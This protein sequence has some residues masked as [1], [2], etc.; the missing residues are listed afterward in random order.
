MNEHTQ[1]DGDGLM[2]V[3]VVLVS[4]QAAILAT[5]VIEAL[6]FTS[7]LGGS[8]LSGVALTIAAT[9]VTGI[10]AVGLGRRVRWARRWTLVAESGVLAL[11]MLD[12]VVA[13][14]VMGADLAVMPLLTR[15]ALPFV[16]IVLLRRPAVRSLFG[17]SR[18]LEVAA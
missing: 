15:V 2:E 3:V 12:L 11:A 5:G 18:S 7:L 13:P 6:V 10:T 14:I 17:P 1:P 4:I 9:V 8:A 16:V